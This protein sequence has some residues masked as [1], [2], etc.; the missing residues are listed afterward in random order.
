ML[1]ANLPWATEKAAADRDPDW[2]RSD[3]QSVREYLT[4]L[5]QHLPLNKAAVEQFVALYEK[6]RFSDEELTREEYDDA[7]AALVALLPA[8]ARRWLLWRC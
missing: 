1:R 6:A 3:H 8:Y 2:E 4:M 5:A 7:V